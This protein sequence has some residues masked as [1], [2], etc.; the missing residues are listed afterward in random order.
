[1]SARIE[2]PKIKQVVDKFIAAH[3]EMGGAYR[4]GLELFKDSRFDSKIG[5]KA[6]KGIDRGATEL[7]GQAADE[8]GAVAGEFSKQ[9]SAQARTA[10]ITALI[11]MTTAAFGA[12]ALFAWVVGR[13]IVKPAAQLVTDLEH[14]AAG[15]LA[16]PIHSFYGDE[17]GRIAASAERTRVDLKSLI[18]EASSAAH[19]VSSASVQLSSTVLQITQA[20]ERQSESVSSTAAAVEQMAVSVSSVAQNAEDVRTLSAQTVTRSNESCENLA[21][22][23]EQI[24]RA[25][26]A[27][28]GI[29]NSVNH[30]VVNTQSILKM[31]RDVKEI[32]SQ[33]NLLALNAA[34]EAARAG[35][36]GRGFAVVADEVR[37]LAEK[38]N[39]AASQI[40]KI[41]QELTIESADVERAI[42]QGFSALATSDETLKQV[43]AGLKAANDS[44]ASANAGVDQ[45]TGAV[46]EQTIA[47]NE[48]AKNVESIAQMAEETHASVVEASQSADM[49]RGLAETVQAS[50][51]RFRVA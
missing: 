36:A 2:E 19:S 30:F 24:E 38:S 3:A 37:S 1:L 50:T 10:V 26:A 15:D 9:A 22:L 31:T 21:Q 48:I 20:S 17:I 6:V 7:L 11:I 41:T 5:D 28:D 47:S 35:E 49:L 13:R 27:A 18:T 33:T 23:S 16:T 45:I 42:Q 14:M 44:V 39:H 29:T 46:K 32:A 25:R 12:F 8:L 43:L 34:I 51:A 40:D 4:K